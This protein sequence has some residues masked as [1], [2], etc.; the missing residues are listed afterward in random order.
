MKT[1][2]RLNLPDVELKIKEENQNTFVF[3]FI[4]KK[5]LVLT[6]EEWVR[7]HLVSY[8]I[9]H[10]HFPASLISLEAGLKYNSL[11]KRTDILIYNKLGKPLLIIECKAPEVPISQKVLAQVS[12]YN[13]TIKAHFLC[14]TNGIKHYCWT[15]NSLTNKFDF[16]KQIPDFADIDGMNG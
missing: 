4:R 12:I 14:V 3:D 10:K 9:I 7:Q 11:N 1:F 2:E 16:Q 5:W 6:P 15:F 13:K 8:L